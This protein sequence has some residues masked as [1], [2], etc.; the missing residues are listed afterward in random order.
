MCKLKNLVTISVFLAYILLSLHTGFLVDNYELV[1]STYTRD[2][3]DLK[4]CLDQKG[5]SPSVLVPRGGSFKYRLLNIPWQ[6]KPPKTKPL[7]FLG[8]QSDTDVVAMVSC[9]HQIGIHLVIKGG[10]HSFGKYSY[11]NS[12]S[13]V[14]DLRALNSITLNTSEGTVTVGAGHLTGPLGWQLWS[15]GKLLL[16]M[17]SCPTVG[18]SGSTLGGGLGSFGG[19]YGLTMDQVLEMQVVTAPGNIAV[20]NRVE[21]SDLFWALRGA[22]SNSFGIVTKFIFRAIPAP[23]A[24]FQGHLTFG[25]Q[26]F[27][28]VAAVWQSLIARQTEAT[29]YTA[30]LATSGETI[31]W[32]MAD[33][34]ANEKHFENLRKLFPPALNVSKATYT[35]PE[36][37]FHQAK[38]LCAQIMRDGVKLE[39]P[40][41]LGNLNRLSAI[42]MYQERK[43][44]F[45]QKR[46]GKKELF[47]LQKFL[48]GRAL[49]NVSVWFE[50]FGG[51][52]RKVGINE[53]AFV[54]RG[55]TLY[56]AVANYQTEHPN[57]TANAI[58][59]AHIQD[60]YDLGK[61]LFNHKET[62][63]NYVE[64]DL[65]DYLE[66]YYGGGLPKLVYIKQKYDPGNFFNYPQSIPVKL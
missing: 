56:L 17:G 3:N 43:S 65:E 59:R 62:Y 36:F 33:L 21:N 47:L 50:S 57:D 58:A 18:I 15:T 8:P 24:V 48:Q 30:V 29:T 49:T 40:S 10:G 31:R 63:Q 5:L 34:S 26:Q 53:T 38:V 64:P 41:D 37:L 55:E 9:C 32:R 25:L 66:R 61:T 39:K 12:K 7:A 2:L 46:V 54:H 28:E 44:F 6:M 20:A 51:T 13:V 42:P 14:I 23:P 1:A 27:A 22:G 35:F 19:M 16:P 11:G 52:P 60:F 45:V 4:L